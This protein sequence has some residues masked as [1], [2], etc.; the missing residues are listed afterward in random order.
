[1]IRTILVF[2]AAC[3]W[4]RS[5]RSAQEAPRRPT[6]T[7]TPRPSPEPTPAPEPAAPGAG[8]GGGP[9]GQSDLLQS[10]DRRHRQL[11]RLRRATTPC[12]PPLPSR[13]R[14]RR[15]RSRRSS[16]PTP[17]P[18][19]SSRSRNDGVEVEEGYVTFLTLPWQ[20]Q[21][22]AGKFKVQFGK[23]NTHAPPRPA[24]G[25]RAPAD[26]R[27]P[28]LPGHRGRGEGDLRSRRSSSLPG[29]TFSEALLPGRRRQARSRSSTRPSKGD[30]A[31]QRPVPRLPGLRRRPQPRDRASPT[32]TATTARR[33][34]TR[35]ASRTS[36]SSTA[37]S[38]SRARPTAPSSCAASTS[39]ASA[40]SPTARRTRRASSSAA[41]TSSPAAGTRA[42]ATSSPTT[43]T[44]ATLRDK[45]VA[46]TLT[47]M[48][49]EFSHAPRRVP[50][51][52]VR[53]GHQGQRGL[54]ADPV[55]HRR[56]RRPSILRVTHET[57]QL[58]PS[59]RSCP[60]PRRRP[61]RQRQGRHQPPGLRL[62]RRRRRRRARRDLRA[63]E[64]LSGPALRRA[65]PSFVLKLSRADLLIVAGLE[66]EIGYLPPLIDQSR[67][68]KI[69]PG[70][71]GYLDASAGCDILERP[72][73]R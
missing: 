50:L 7:P 38:R 1:M 42:R 55:R 17:A 3:C 33:R 54:P 21:A 35:R 24:V 6:P 18:T 29:D 37:G 36:T 5:R 28:A 48:P 19:S 69:R 65:K 46:A 61:S 23:I 57:H 70:A 51:P 20:M 11:P 15:S 12:S 47:F 73:G 26:R 64:G 60:W 2:A 62:D 27:H 40:S 41:T 68:E 43:P 13:S 22:K 63:R 72:T 71:P 44:N 52:R 49:S 25:G 56:P 10:R 53:P 31:L 67:N 34:P 58:S 30:L 8:T 39:G 14:S 9:G 66:L 59:P 32:R 45:G 4:P 16:I